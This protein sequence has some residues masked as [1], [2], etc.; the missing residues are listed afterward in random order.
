MHQRRQRGDYDPLIVAI[1][2]ALVI[3]MGSAGAFLLGAWWLGYPA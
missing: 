3:L 1:N 2:A